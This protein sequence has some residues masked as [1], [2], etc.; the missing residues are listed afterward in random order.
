MLLDRRNDTENRE[1]RGHVNQHVEDQRSH[2]EGAPADH[3]QHDVTG[4]RDGREGEEAF[5]V[6]LPDGEE[7]RHRDRQHR[8]G[9][10]QRL[11]LPDHRPEDLHQHGHQHERRRAFRHHRQVGGHRR[12]R[13][14]IGVGGPEVERDQ[15]NLEPQPR[16]EEDHGH[17][18]QR[19]TRNA[20]R[21][22]VEIERP[23]RPVEERDS[24][25]HQPAG[26][27]GAEDVL[28][29]RLGRIT[30][31]LV[32]RHQTGHRHRSQL[33]ADKEKQEVARADHQIHAQQRR[34]GQDVELALLVGRIPAAQPRIGLQEDD[35]RPDGQHALDDGVHRHVLE[36][37][38]E[39]FARSPRNDIDRDLQRE[40][41]AG[42]GRKPAASP[43]PRDQVIEKQQDD[44]R[45]E[46]HFGLH[47]GKYVAVIHNRLT[48]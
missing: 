5:Q 40:Q 28:R 45:D 48:H 46:R 31:V 15:R 25:E 8:H 35:Q 36:H 3:G 32:E 9:I 17:D 43:L 38:P 37:A 19:R 7:V 1:V 21:H 47:R 39:H 4:L 12:R 41:S 33:H 30:L 34:E 20:R 16:E 2:A 11:P 23:G 13:A 24:I 22:I 6:L 29:T 18:L 14:L 26:E 44:H 10:K 42:D 27:E